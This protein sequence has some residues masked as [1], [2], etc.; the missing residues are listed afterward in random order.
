MKDYKKLIEIIEKRLDAFKS[1]KEWSDFISLLSALDKPLKSLPQSFNLQTFPKH[2]LYKR[3]NQCLNPTLPSGVHNKVIQTYTIILDKLDQNSKEIEEFIFQNLLLGFFSFFVYAKTQT[4]KNFLDF[5]HDK[6]LNLNLDFNNYIRNIFIGVFPGIEED[7]EL[8]KKCI[9]IIYK[10]K[11]K[12]REENF[13]NHFFDVFFNISE[14]RNGMIEFIL[15]NENLIEEVKQKSELKEKKIFF[16]IDENLI[17]NALKAGL[18]EK[19]QIVVRGT[20][21]MLNLIFTY[22]DFSETHKIELMK[23]LIAL[24]TKKEVGLNKRIY[25]FLD[26]SGNDYKKVAKRNKNYKI[27]IKNEEEDTI[28]YDYFVMAMNSIL[29]KNGSSAILFFR[30]LNVF[31][32]KEEVC[33]YIVQKL[34]VKGLY[35][36]FLNRENSEIKSIKKAFDVFAVNSDLWYIWF[37]IFKTMND[38]FNDLNNENENLIKKSKQYSIEEKNDNKNI[39]QESFSNNDGKNYTNFGQESYKNNDKNIE[40]ENDKNIGQEYEKFLSDNINNEIDK[41]HEQ[42]S[43]NN[44][45]IEEK[46]DFLD[47][48][49]DFNIIEDNNSKINNDNNDE[50][51]EINSNEND[52]NKNNSDMLKN[53]SEINIKNILPD[54]L[55]K[56]D[57]S[58]AEKNYENKK[59]NIDTFEESNYIS[60]S[61]KSDKDINFTKNYDLSCNEENTSNFYNNREKSI[62]LNDEENEKEQNFNQEQDMNNKLF[63]TNNDLTVNLEKF[64]IN[65]DLN[66]NKKDKKIFDYME[67][68]IYALK[69]LQIVEKEILEIHLPFFMVLIIKYNFLL[70]KKQFY[71][72]LEVCFDLI[73]IGSNKEANKI[74]LLFEFV[75]DFYDL[76]KNENINLILNS[77]IKTLAF[78]ITKLFDE[79]NNFYINNEILMLFIKHFGIENIE[80]DFYVKYYNFLIY[81]KNEKIDDFYNTYEKASLILEHTKESNLYEI[82]KND[83]YL[84]YEILLNN[85]FTELIVKYNIFFDRKFEEFMVNDFQD[86]K[87]ISKIYYFLHRIICTGNKKFNI[88][89]DNNSTIV[90]LDE[91]KTETEI[92]SNNSLK[93]LQNEYYYFFTVLTVIINY[94]MKSEENILYLTNKNDRKDFVSFI[95]SIYRFNSIFF[96]VYNLI[97]NSFIFTKDLKY[98]EEPKINNM[99][100]A[101]TIIHSFLD[102]SI[103]FRIFLKNEIDLDKKLDF[104]RILVYLSCRNFYEI[105]INCFK[106]INKMLKFKI[107]RDEEIIQVDFIEFFN[108]LN[109][110]KNKDLLIKSFNIVK[111]LADTDNIELSNMTFDYLKNINLNEL[112]VFEVV[113]FIFS[114]GN[115]NHKKTTLINYLILFHN[116]EINFIIIDYIFRNRIYWDSI[117]IGNLCD[118]LCKR[119]IN[120]CKEIYNFYSINK[121]ND[122]KILS[123]TDLK[124]IENERFCYN[125]IENKN[126][127][128]DEIYFINKITKLFLEKEDKIF[129][130]FILKSD[131]KSKWLKNCLLLKEIHGLILKRPNPNF[132]FISQIEENLDKNL[133]FEY[134]TNSSNVFNHISTVPRNRLNNVNH[135]LWILKAF[136]KNNDIKD[137]Q[138]AAFNRI[139][140]NSVFILLKCT[141]PV[142]KKFKTQEERNEMALDLFNILN[143]VILIIKE[144]ETKSFIQ[145]YFYCIYNIL[146]TKNS[147]LIS[148][149]LKKHAEL[150]IKVF[151]TRFWARNFLEL[152]TE[153]R[154][155]EDNFENLKVKSEIMSFFMKKNGQRLADFNAKF[156]VGFFVSK[157]VEILTKKNAIKRISFM[158]FCSENDSLLTFIYIIAQR[159]TEFFSSNVIELRKEAFFL[160]RMAIYKTSPAN[161]N[162]VW[163]VLISEINSFFERLLGDKISKNEL[164]VLAEIIKILELIF[165]LKIDQLIEIK[166]SF[167]KPYKLQE[168]QEEENY[169]SHAFFK[170]LMFLLKND[171]EMETNDNLKFKIV[172]KRLSFY[173]ENT[174]QNLK[175]LVYFVGNVDDYYTEMDFN[176]FEIDHD[177]IRDLVLEEFLEKN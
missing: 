151:F 39:E 132:I 168:N 62:D 33:D 29:E 93:N 117:E 66:D 49:N 131:P 10:V 134:I 173:Q 72:F 144:N 24:T 136:L 18:T 90:K 153:I 42:E 73:K 142:I 105:Q 166:W 133:I 57:K 91:V 124:S 161:L 21:D 68:I 35:Q 36:I 52:F 48:E 109:I 9:Q 139:L 41:K 128:I 31:I 34:M 4:K 115:I 155:F 60:E 162:I 103:R 6:I 169:D 54:Y 158:F 123:D 176:A 137:I 146:R 1:A 44:D 27:S 26:Q 140:E 107:F 177:K 125:S 58:N 16:Y 61:S 127:K 164:P 63:K 38:L 78:E 55:E 81:H 96:F 13:W 23:S 121:K 172:E 40:Q 118:I 80:S 104:F 51:F 3:L 138:P 154:F 82:I 156:D 112:L 71:N 175:D 12:T 20:L 163:P 149:V 170:K 79:K 122:R 67:G 50:S 167:L 160:A 84:M 148:L 59:Q 46:K 75:V 70:E 110:N 111:I 45:Q 83:S 25:T 120:K 100:S 43:F 30:I 141:D 87:N 152:F 77:F 129:I 171:I 97:K 89:Y 126:T 19:S 101:F 15:K 106:I 8:A 108:F 22:K 113:F 14:Q 64:N 88:I 37:C 98:I 159:I 85:N 7:A 47:N 65:N 147:F 143:S 157:D 174:I 165:V 119:M 95:D 94:Y 17:I 135:Y 11:S 130:D 28:V 150:C 32:D 53:N 86:Q 74:D 92:S 102:Y 116:L 114:L 145:T 56:N 99:L 5:I 69:N 2:Y 76:E